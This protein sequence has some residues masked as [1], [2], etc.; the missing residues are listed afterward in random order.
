M[1]I[2]HLLSLGFSVTTGHLQIISVTDVLNN[3][4]NHWLKQKFLLVWHRSA[5]YL[6][7][8]AICASTNDMFYSEKVLY[9]K[10]KIFYIDYNN[11]KWRSYM[12]VYIFLKGFFS[13]WVFTRNFH[14]YVYIWVENMH[15]HD[16]FQ[17]SSN[18][19]DRAKLM[20]ELYE[21]TTSYRQQLK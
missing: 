21:Y 20:N 4:L 8:L 14:L 12:Y 11:C 15:D 6:D 1:D 17:T 2:Y 5:H 3:F 19:D 9:I 16:D 10:F 7:I 13:I 18:N